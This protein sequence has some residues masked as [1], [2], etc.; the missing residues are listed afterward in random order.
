MYLT[1]I[2]LPLP[3]ACDSTLCAVLLTSDWRNYHGL[4]VRDTH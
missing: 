2:L 4:D 3:V 1:E